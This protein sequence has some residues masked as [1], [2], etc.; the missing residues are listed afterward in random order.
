MSFKGKGIFTRRLWVKR[1]NGSSNCRAAIVVTFGCN[2][3]QLWSVSTVQFLI[4]DVLIYWLWNDQ[5][6]DYTPDSPN[7][8]EL[9]LNLFVRSQIPCATPAC[10]ETHDGERHN[11]V[12]L[13][14]HIHLRSFTHLSLHYIICIHTLLTFM[15]ILGKHAHLYELKALKTSWIAWK[16]VQSSNKKQSLSFKN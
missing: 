8:G 9:N 14:T 15:H 2:L 16:Y 3:P 12:N 6:R 11:E 1:P 5:S 4:A 7:Q 13:G 10:G